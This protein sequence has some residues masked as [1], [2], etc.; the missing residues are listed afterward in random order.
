LSCL[1]A[2]GASLVRGQVDPLLLVLLCGMAAAALRGRSGQAG[3]WLAGAICLKV[4]PAFLLVYPLWRRDGRWLAGSAAGLVLGLGIVPAAVFGPGQTLAYYRE[5][6]EVLLRP[7][8]TE[9]GDQTR[10]QELT[11]I[12]ATDSQSLLAILHNTRYL[13]RATRPPVASPYERW[14][15]WGAG[16]L[17][18]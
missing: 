11:Q 12:T 17:L 4:I 9:G 18:T 5:W 1:P 6:Q 8:L 10:A 7:A 3:F 15:H 14:A 13:D 2:L 16:G